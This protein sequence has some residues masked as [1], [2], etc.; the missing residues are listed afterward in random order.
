MTDPSTGVSYSL[1]PI[2]VKTLFQR[3]FLA[4]CTWQR[5]FSDDLYYDHYHNQSISDSHTDMDTDTN[6]NTVFSSNS[7][8]NSNNSPYTLP[9]SGGSGTSRMSDAQLLTQPLLM[10]R[11]KLTK[12][13]KTLMF[14]SFDISGEAKERE[15]LRGKG[16]GVVTADEERMSTRRRKVGKLPKFLHGDISGSSSDGD[17][18]GERDRDRD[19][20]SNS[21]CMSE[22]DS[23]EEQGF[24]D[25]TRSR[26]RSR[27]IPRRAAAAAAHWYEPIGPPGT[28]CALDPPDYSF[29]LPLHRFLAAMVLEVVKHPQYLS[30]VDSI[31]TTIGSAGR[32]CNAMTMQSA[33]SSVSSS[34]NAADDDASVHVFSF[35]ELP[36]RSLV[37][38]AQV[39]S[40]MW[41]KNGSSM[42][43]QYINYG[44]ASL[45]RIAR[46]LDLF[47]LQLCM[48]SVCSSD[49]AISS[50]RDRSG[51]SHDFNSF[52][53]LLL[54][55][56]DLLPVFTQPQPAVPVPVSGEGLF[57]I[58]SSAVAAESAVQSTLLEE[59]LLLL[60]QIFTELPLP[61]YQEQLDAS[62]ATTVD[63][64]LSAGAGVAE[65]KPVSIPKTCTSDPASASV[66]QTMTASLVERSKILLRR[67]VIH[68]LASSPSSY[69]QLQ[70][71]FPCVSDFTKIPT[72]DIDKV[73][74]DVSIQRGDSINAATGSE[75]PKRVLKPESWREY[76]P[77]FYHM[78]FSSH[79]IAYENRPKVTKPAPIVQPPLPCHLAFVRLRSTFLFSDVIYRML[80]TLTLSAAAQR[81]TSLKEYDAV[82]AWK[83]EK[84]SKLTVFTRV[85]HL[86]TLMIHTIL[87][88]TET[89]TETE[90]IQMQSDAKCSGGRGIG[91]MAKFAEFLLQDTTYLCTNQAVALDGRLSSTPSSSSADNTTSRHDSSSS[92]SNSTVVARLPCVLGAL[93]EI[94]SSLTNDVSEANLSMW[95]QWVIQTCGVLSPTCKHFIDQRF[96][97]INEETKRVELE[98]RK[99]RARERAMKAMQSSAQSFSTHVNKAKSSNKTSTAASA[100]AVDTNQETTNSISNKLASLSRKS[101]QTGKSEVKGDSDVDE[102]D[103]SDTNNDDD[104][105]DNDDRYDD[106]GASSNAQIPDCIIC[107]SKSKQTTNV[108]VSAAEVAAAAAAQSRIAHML[109]SGNH[110][111]NMYKDWVDKDGELGTCMTANDS[112]SDTRVA[113]VSD[114]LVGHLCFTQLSSVLY[115]HSLPTLLHVSTGAGDDIINIDTEKATVNASPSSKSIQRFRPS[116]LHLGFCGHSVHLSCLNSYIKAEYSKSELQSGLLLDQ[117][118][119][120]FLCPLCKQICNSVIPHYENKAMKWSNMSTRNMLKHKHQHHQHSTTQQPIAFTVLPSFLE[121]LGLSSSSSSLSLSSANTGQWVTDESSCAVVGQRQQPHN[122]SVKLIRNKPPPFASSLHIESVSQW[123]QQQQQ[124]HHALPSSSSSSSS[125]FM[126]RG[127]SFEHPFGVSS[128]SGTAAAAA[129]SRGD[130]GARMDT[131]R[132]SGG[133]LGAVSGSIYADHFWI[134]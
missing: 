1:P 35:A 130:G 14:E 79:Q 29:H 17:G 11:K 90:R 83:L 106:D 38:G 111:G 34:T 71:V 49:H 131:E 114:D 55:H 77:S 69:S 101:A 123:H 24:V 97:D 5:K 124:P 70:E 102:E 37:F 118:R 22:E 134:K 4:L 103:F 72:G 64:I 13:N 47:L 7:N 95:L 98:T 2:H 52:L 65:S 121:S 74:F 88:E 129:V 125:T 31:L 48:T 28:V 54:Y 126:D 58:H 76:D 75:A 30:L 107:Q 87:Q 44:E 43:D 51:G 36:I 9:G 25:L 112:S 116:R 122:T 68:K 96:S 109:N 110:P 93:L 82:R 99:K 59:F 3:T 104:A 6:T 42:A 41:T 21:R 33:S 56:F 132:G 20:R 61:C 8:S 80:Q 127:F 63:D 23:D 62:S 128:S 18:D 60:I 26:S 57:D 133:S 105:D 81:V 73:I 78:T 16:E 86:L 94:H 45:C 15:E 67:E 85:L 66:G 84:A 50:G 119:R 120:Q 117:K 10:K 115:N 108:G 40:S 100:D 53:I 91:S 46:D 12:K 19:S 32:T 113:T 92:S 27:L 89:Q 39:Q